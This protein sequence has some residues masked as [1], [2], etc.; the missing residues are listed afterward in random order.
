MSAWVDMSQKHLRR[1][2]K[3][4]VDLNS[5]GDTQQSDMLRA[6]SK[7]TN[8]RLILGASFGAENATER[9][10]PAMQVTTI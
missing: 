3:R 6:V 5:G 2:S 9:S 10:R 8:L 1:A 7:L 4:K